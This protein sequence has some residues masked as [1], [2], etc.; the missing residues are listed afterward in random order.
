MRC[1]NLITLN[2]RRH[3]RELPDGS[4]RLLIPKGETKT[5]RFDLVFDLDAETSKMLRWVRKDFL[6]AID[7]DPEGDLFAMPGGTRRG[8]GSFCEAVKSAIKAHI[9]IEMTV[10]QFRHAAA[11]LYLDTHPEDFETIRQLLGHSFGK[12]TLLYAGLS[13]ER[14]SRSYGESR[15]E[16]AGG[17][18]RTA[19]PGPQEWKKGISAM[20]IQFPEKVRKHLPL[21]LWPVDD[22]TRFEA[23]FRFDD[24]FDDDPAPGA[25]LSEGSRLHAETGYRRWLGFL[26]QLYPSDLSLRAEQRVVPGRIRDY[27]DQLGL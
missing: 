11:K 19:L 15:L 5:K 1:Q 27:I 8:Q 24:V 13:S 21:N 4:I 26:H 25:H 3:I 14:A 16:E 23:A 18:E 2:G 12:T 6:P 9:G 7:A 20:D 10:H 22:R 17:D